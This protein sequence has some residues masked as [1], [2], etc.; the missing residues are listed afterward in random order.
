MC[1]CTYSISLSLSFSLYEPPKHP[2]SI[3]VFRFLARG[4]S[5]EYTNHTARI[6]TPY[7]LHYSPIETHDPSPCPSP[8]PRL[9]L[10]RRRRALVLS[11]HRRIVFARPS[12]RRA[13]V[14]A[15][16]RTRS[17]FTNLTFYLNN[18]TTHQASSSS[19]LSRGWPAPQQQLCVQKSGMLM[20][21]MHAHARQRTVCQCLL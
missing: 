18:I 21:V 12:R 4:F 16:A 8:A 6:S 9:T 17:H 1:V 7:T 20:I 11:S 10:S 2:V 13:R 15:S 19:S 14:H 5:L 3:K